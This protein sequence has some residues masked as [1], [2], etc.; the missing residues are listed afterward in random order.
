MKTVL[1]KIQTM[2]RL[3]LGKWYKIFL[4]CT[5]LFNNRDNTSNEFSKNIIN[6]VCGQASKLKKIEKKERISKESPTRQ[7]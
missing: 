4:L 5:M 7:N 2:Q 1:N 3:Q 6:I